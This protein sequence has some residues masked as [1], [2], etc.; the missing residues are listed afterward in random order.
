MTLARAGAVAKPPAKV[1]RLAAV[2]ELLGK[3]T[4]LAVSGIKR[5]AGGV[6]RFP[7]LGCSGK[8]G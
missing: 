4:R 6:G 1:Q 5:G 2:W 7:L 3:Q 8:E